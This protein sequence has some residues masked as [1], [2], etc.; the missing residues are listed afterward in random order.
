VVTMYNLGAMRG[1]EDARPIGFRPAE[2]SGHAGFGET[3]TTAAFEA[4]V[5]HFPAEKISIAW[6]GNASRVPVDQILGEVMKLIP[7]AKA[8]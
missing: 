3:G 2:I 7:K 4:A 6:T 8:K 5:Y 1:D